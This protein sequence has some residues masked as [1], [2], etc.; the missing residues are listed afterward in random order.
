MMFNIYTFALI[1]GLW[2]G[3]NVLLVVWLTPPM[4]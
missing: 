2:L 1:T 4:E 3:F